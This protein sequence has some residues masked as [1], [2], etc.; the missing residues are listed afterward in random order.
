[1][2]V[3]HQELLSFKYICLIPKISPLEYSEEISSLI[4]S[5]QPLN[6]RCPQGYLHIYVF[7]YVNQPPIFASKVSVAIL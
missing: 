7:I 1:M 5:Y 6:L 4:E 2:F 3:T